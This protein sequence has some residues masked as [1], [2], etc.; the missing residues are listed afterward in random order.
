MTRKLLRAIRVKYQSETIREY[1]LTYKHGQFDKT[2][3]ASTRVYGVGGCSAGSNAFALP[4]C[5]G[6]YHEHTFDYHARAEEEGFDDVVSV[7][8]ENN[9]G[10]VSNTNAHANALTKST[11]KSWAGG[12]SVVLTDQ[13][14]QLSGTASIHGS[15]G[16]RVEN[17]GTYDFDGDG[18]VDQV[19]DD[20]STLRLIANKPAS[21]GQSFVVAPA[22]AIA[23]QLQE[24]G[25]ESHNSWG[26]DVSATAKLGDAFGVGGTAGFSNSTARA[27]KFFTDLDGDG[28]IDFL[29]AGG[30]SKR[31]YPCPSGICFEDITYNATTLID[32]S[33]DAELNDAAEDINA[34][35]IPGAPVMQWVAPYTG[36]IKVNGM[37]GLVRPGTVDGISVGLFRNDEMLAGWSVANPS[38]PVWV[39]TSLDVR[40]GD[41]MYLY[42]STGANDGSAGLVDEAQLLPLSPLMFDFVSAC[43]DAT[44]T[45]AVAKIEGKEP[46]GAGVFSFTS[47]QL[48]VVAFSPAP[49]AC[50]T[51]CTP[52]GGLFLDDGESL[53]IEVLSQKYVTPQFTTVDLTCNGSATVQRAPL[54]FRK[55]K[56][57]RIASKTP[58]VGGYRGWNTTFWNEHEPF[59]PAALLAAHEDIYSLPGCAAPPAAPPDP[60]M[61]QS[62]MTRVF[63]TAIK[64]EAAFDGTPLT[65][66]ARAWV[67]AQSAAFVVPSSGRMNAGAIGGV[68]GSSPPGTVGPVTAG[69]LY[70]PGYGRLSTTRSYFIGANLSTSGAGPASVPNLVVPG[71]QATVTRSKTK[72][73]TDVL[74]LTGDGIPDVVAGDSAYQG[75]IGNNPSPSL[76]YQFGRI[77]ERVANEYMFST[78]LNAASNV[79][80]SHGRTAY[81]LTQPTGPTADWSFGTSRSLA[82]GRSQT[83]DDV[84]DVNGDG[85]PDLVQRRGTEIQ[86]RYNLGHELGALETFATMDP[87]FAD[88]HI[89][90]F[91][92][93]ERSTPILN[94]VLNSSENAINHA[95]TVTQSETWSIGIFIAKGSRTKRIS[96]T[97]VTRDFADINGDGLPDL[98]LKKSGAPIRVQFNRGAGFAPAQQWHTPTWGGLQLSPKFHA[99]FDPLIDAGQYVVTGDDVLSGTGTEKAKSYSGGVLVPIWGPLYIGANLSKSTDEDTYELSLMDIT[100]DG[101]PDHVL[102]RKQPSATEP[103]IFI[104]KNRV[105]IESNLL[106][107]VTRPLGGT[108]KLAYSA[109]PNTQDMPSMR[110]VLS[111]V[112]VDDG[113]DLGVSFA[114]PNLVTT[115][116]YDD[117]Y[118]HRLE[119]QFMGFGKVTTRRADGGTIEQYFDNRSFTLQGL[120]QKEIRRDSATNIVQE[121]RITYEVRA[122]TG[123]SG[124]LTAQQAC[125]DAQHELLKRI[126]NNEACTPKVPVVTRDEDIRGELGTTATKK[127]VVRDT[128][129]DRFGNVTGSIDEGDNAITNDTL[130]ITATYKNDTTKW[131][132]GR[133][134]QI[135]ARDRIMWG[136]LLRARAGRYDTLGRLKKIDVTT[137]TGTATTLL[138]YDAFGNL[139]RV[140]TPP[141]ASGQTQTYNA[142]FDPTVATYPISTTDAFGLTSTAEYDLRFGVA[143]KETDVNGSQLLRTTDGFGRLTSVRGPY[144]LGAPG[145]TLEYYA[146]ESPARAVSTT[147][148]SAPSDYTGPLP[149]PLTTVTI[150]DGLGRAIEV[151]KTAVV[152]GVPGM[153]TAGLVQ[154]DALDRITKTWHPFFTPGASTGFIS[155][156]ATYATSTSY[157]ELDRATTTIAPDGATETSSYA[158]AM[159]PTNQ[160]LFRT[161]HT[162]VVPGLNRVREEYGDHLGRMRAYVEHPTAVTSSITK[163]E[164]LPTGELK[165]IV[166]A[167]NN[168]T[169][170]GYD[171]RGLRTSLANADTGLREHVFD[172]MGNQVAL[173]EPNH[174]ALN[175]QVTYNY[176][177]N[178]LASINFP[179][180]PDVSFEYGAGGRLT[181]V[182]DETGT[183]EYAYGALGETRR[184]LRTFAPAGATQPLHFEQRFTY[185]S[186][187]RELQ[188]RYPDGELITNIY[189]N[190]GA[191]VA[192]KGS[193]DGWE[194]TYATGMRYDVFGNRTRMEVGRV[195]TTWTFDPARVRLNNVVSTL[196]PPAAAATMIQNLSYAY[197]AAGNPTQIANSLASPAVEPSALP[198]T[199]ALTLTY[200]GVDRLATATGTGHLT[201][202]RWSLYEQHFS[203]SPSHNLLGKTRNHRIKRNNVTY[204]PPE[205]NFALTYQYSTR[206]HLPDQVGTL[207]MQ[208]D[209][210][211][212]PTRRHDTTSGVEQILTWDD[213]D[214]LVQLT[215]TSGVVQSNLYDSSGLRVR[216]KSTTVSGSRTTIFASQYFNLEG[217]QPTSEGGI[218]HIFAGGQRIATVLGTFNSTNAPTAP[219]TPGTPYY[220]HGD[221][222]GSTTV[223]TDDLGGV[224]QSL[225]YFVDGEVWI[226]RAP[227]TTVNGFLF[228]GKPYDP[229]TKFYDYGQRFYDPRTSL[230][231]GVDPAFLDG[232]DKSVGR[233]LMLSVGGFSGQS[234][235]RNIDPDG[236]DWTDAINIDYKAGRIGPPIK[237]DLRRSAT[238]KALATLHPYTAMASEFLD[239]IS[240]DPLPPI[241]TTDL[242]S[243]D[244]E[245]RARAIADFRNRAD[246]LLDTKS[247][248]TGSGPRGP[249][250]GT[251]KT[252]GQASSNSAPTNLGVPPSSFQPKTTIKKPYARPFGTTKAQRDSAK[253][254]ACANCGTV[255]PNQI[256]DHKKP[257][258]VEYYET[259]TNNPVLQ[260]SVGA[261]QAHCPSCSNMQ[262]GLLSAFSQR[263][264]RKLGLDK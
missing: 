142:T 232:T 163:Y 116:T 9:A 156:V 226:D 79:T 208:Y 70:E 236:R 264:R 237:M 40:A 91:E 47:S 185:D 110:A 1:V 176:Q 256:A 234:P 207:Q 251:S 238:L 241:D 192:V 16:D 138:D 216:R 135:R 152:D 17:V 218:K 36:N 248:G 14:S 22:S 222:L 201:Q 217:E 139:A 212:N 27:K 51:T 77:R 244:P 34:R 146:N 107:H 8:A 239:A 230:W 155:P 87:Q 30:K 66:G 262:G 105:S 184:V 39:S 190:A 137:G 129:R 99:T 243:K 43:T 64:P 209:A 92:H 235:F 169:T 149:P 206:P 164:Y 113:V 198:R 194:H 55:I 160:T 28:Y 253:G 258:V 197:D 21:T 177:L 133:P 233:P 136:T 250:Q 85:L 141:N 81:M 56:A 221:H 134:T 125:I 193:G 227:S 181:R 6:E 72:T 101:R 183:I 130:Y 166:D 96:S 12:L 199:S 231:L 161:Q 2:L 148:T 50:L 45:K 67:A 19:Y 37:V 159:A 25:V 254:K 165:T 188:L 103:K 119:K 214:R 15:F 196:Q 74:D 61:C 31:S 259:G 162:V 150:L 97:R 65:N 261:V 219:A 63:R 242:L 89:D 94:D 44:C 112:E 33:K 247:V 173:I 158:I 62:E 26:V 204:T 93:L 4:A 84:I 131:I 117:S 54:I 240:D 144:D 88:E 124:V 132:L 68:G 20:G 168:T 172:L 215:D 76:N 122:V 223:V 257:L 167:E 170:I 195:V 82:V 24:L 32:P 255:T 187:G 224:H 106:V 120:L 145:I 182:T 123:P 128:A 213:D 228:N 52:P 178:R 249:P 220:V 13:T 200:D 143:T 48:R 140:E 174:R 78:D 104:K 98:L 80:N 186:L 153:T 11:T 41:A 59:A 7:C 5:G 147:R 121:R 18:D 108:I 157:D 90:A 179:S 100:G 246:E 114:S 229:E 57:D 189:D 118:F 3:L 69:G 191:L 58:F 203:Y 95:T 245:V 71:F 180:K 205:T 35:A 49:F 225:E 23:Q 86:V 154:R 102:R 126:P 53:S 83:T 171:L 175:T 29:D 75:S 210:S 109:Q 38:A 202:L 111:R 263:M 151:S 252:K 10:C 115:F 73:T 42:V 260:K 211:G 60:A 127:R 46:T